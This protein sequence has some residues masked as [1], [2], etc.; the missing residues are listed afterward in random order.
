MK[1]YLAAQCISS[2]VADV[3]DI[4]CSHLKLAVS[5][6]AG[7]QQIPAHFARPV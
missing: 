7:H 2:R 1:V 4:C 6:L 5:G 3:L